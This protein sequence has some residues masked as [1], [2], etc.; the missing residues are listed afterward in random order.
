MTLMQVGDC[1]KY[2]LE[3]IILY[4]YIFIFIITEFIFYVITVVDPAIHDSVE[5]SYARVE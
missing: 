1:W 3:A 2:A 5:N 4:Y